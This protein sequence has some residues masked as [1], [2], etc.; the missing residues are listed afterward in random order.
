MKHLSKVIF[1]GIIV[2]M[3]LNSFA[4]NSAKH[5]IDI[6][7]PEVA[8]LGLVTDNSNV[9][10]IHAKSNNVAENSVSFVDKTDVNLVWINY[11]SVKKAHS[12]SRKITALVQGDIPKGIKLKVSASAASSDGKGQLGEPKGSTVLGEQPTEIISNIGSCY[13][14]QG[15]Q[16]GHSLV[17]SLDV[18]EK[19]AELVA[20]NSENITF[21]IVY[22]LAD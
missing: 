19:E 16:H 18:D 10:Q 1:V 20:L 2:V 21:N 22:T 3:A 15:A 12:A 5:N 9:S 14:G 13:T 7:I 17:Y 11:S 8:L 4:Q 6:R